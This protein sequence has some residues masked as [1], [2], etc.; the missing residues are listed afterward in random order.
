[1]SI[2]ENLSFPDYEL[3]VSRRARHLR[4]K[5]TPLGEVVVVI[6]S[7]MDPAR[8]PALLAKKRAWLQSVLQ[9]LTERQ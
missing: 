2:V 9:R 6:P 8:V 1:M 3:R 7:G 4:I 5:V